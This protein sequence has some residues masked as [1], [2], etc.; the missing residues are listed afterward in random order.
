MKKKSWIF[1]QR[2]RDFL[3]QSGTI[4][5][6]GHPHLFSMAGIKL[7]TLK[8]FGFSLNASPKKK[9]QQIDVFGDTLS[10]MNGQAWKKKEESPDGGNS[11]GQWSHLVTG[12]IQLDSTHSLGKSPSWN[13]SSSSPASP[14]PPWKKITWWVM[15]GSCLFFE[16]FYRFQIWKTQNKGYEKELNLYTTKPLVH[17][18]LD[19]RII[20]DLKYWYVHSG[21]PLLSQ[22]L[23]IKPL[24]LLDYHCWWCDVED[25]WRRICQPCAVPSWV[26]QMLS[27]V[28]N[29]SLQ[30]LS[31]PDLGSTATVI[32]QL[33]DQPICCE[34]SNNFTQKVRWA[35][36]ASPSLSYSAT[37]LCSWKGPSSHLQNGSTQLLRLILSSI[38]RVRSF[39]FQV[40]ASVISVMY[41]VIILRSDLLPWNKCTLV[42]PQ[43]C[44][45]AYS[46]N[47][48]NG[49]NT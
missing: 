45:V 4:G 25:L 31:P 43:A 33:L 32:F 42:I 39:K 21:S 15:L 12:W 7:G 36:S 11:S 14:S 8:F 29:L 38:P 22:S 18:A 16:M 19:R 46:S 35:P 48:F 34:A 40:N 37:N 1:T 24:V 5:F 2:M 41:F 47:Y 9:T 17:Q 13:A 27:S 10:I 28:W 23:G 30:D 6:W 20:R 26:K 44:F 3:Y 49:W